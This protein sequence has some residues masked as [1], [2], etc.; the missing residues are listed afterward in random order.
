MT[1][2]DSTLEEIKA[3]IE[4]SELIASYG[5]Q[6]RSAGV[7][8]KACCP[9]HHEKTPSFNINDSKGF[10]HCFGCGESGD[11]FKFVQKMDG[12]TFAEAAK[13]LAESVGI[14]IVEKEDKSAAKR[15]RLYALMAEVAEFYHRCLNSTKEA[16]KAR[17]YLKERDLDEAAQKAFL[18]GY[19]PSGIANMKKWAEKHGYSLKEMEEAGVIIAPKDER[20]QGYHRFSS[21]LMFSIKD[22]QGR[23][24]AFSGRQL[25]ENKNSG[26][27]VNSPETPIFKKSNVLFAFDKASGNIAKDPHHT[28]IVCEGQIDT[29]R[30]HLCGFTTALASQ[31]TAF[32]AEHV[33]ML[34]RVADEVTLVFDDDG[35]GHKATIK[36]AGLC[37]AE[38]LPVRVVS[39]PGGDDP[40]SFLRTHK[41]EEFKALLDSAESIVAFQVRTEFQ[42]ES[43]PKSVEAITR[44]TKAVLATISKSS[45]VVIR[46]GMMKE[47]AALL[48]LP[49][50]ALRQELSGENVSVLSAT[51]DPSEPSELPARPAPPSLSEPALPP[52]PE[53]ELQFAEFLL[54]CGSDEHVLDMVTEFLVKEVFLNDFTWRFLEAWKAG[55][56]A[57]GQFVSSLEGEEKRWFDRIY[58]AGSRSLASTLSVTKLAENNIRQLWSAYLERRLYDMPQTEADDRLRLR[59]D[60][61]NLREERWPEVK[62]ILRKAMKGV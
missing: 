49:I 43:N 34:K 52:P 22:K 60:I 58:L 23:V 62:N 21:R 32:T 30:L 33:K 3:R 7:S 17:Q 44:V 51:S 50:E 59:V 12:L 38:A 11:V 9:F 18:I 16:E 53:I 56:A 19:A 6:V 41:R 8:K 47:A 39:L 2:P 46:E 28:A 24:V 20:D 15:K 40:D 5:I 29:I 13:K 61:Y 57:L 54:A 26:K 31:G 1:I 27:Y 25:V 37:L 35:A 55:T 45:S 10:Y 42:K 36:T 14:E 48:S 4:L